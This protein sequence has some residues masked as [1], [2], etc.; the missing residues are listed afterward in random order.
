MEKKSVYIDLSFEKEERMTKL[1]TKMATTAVLLV[2]ASM[3]MPA[4][5]L[6]RNGGQDPLRRSPIRPRQSMKT[7]RSVSSAVSGFFA[8]TEKWKWVGPIEDPAHPDVAMS[9]VV[10]NLTDDNGD[11]LINEFDSP[12]VVFTISVVV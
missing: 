5:A 7:T 9:P 1:K 3:T 12:E 8:V 6:V 4:H 10:V 11:G 2:V